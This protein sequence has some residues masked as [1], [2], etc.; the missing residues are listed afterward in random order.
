[1]RL[2]SVTQEV[3][4]C[5]AFPEASLHLK[6]LKVVPVVTA[7]GLAGLWALVFRVPVARAEGAFDDPRNSEAGSG[8]GPRSEG[9]TVCF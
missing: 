4:V 3:L 1:M 2:R 9:I 7:G 6:A 8:P 5:G